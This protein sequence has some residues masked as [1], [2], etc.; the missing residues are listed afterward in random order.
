MY[1]SRHNRFKKKRNNTY[2]KNI[3]SEYEYAFETLR[4]KYLE[5]MKSFKNT[6]EEF[7]YFIKLNYISL[8]II[9]LFVL[10]KIRGIYGD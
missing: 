5:D 10:D 9:A 4:W 6:L 2:Y 3:L 1:L 7:K 8:F